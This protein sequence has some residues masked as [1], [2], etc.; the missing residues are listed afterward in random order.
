M[1]LCNFENISHFER[2]GSVKVDEINMDGP[3]NYKRDQQKIR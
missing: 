2:T 1:F 3:E